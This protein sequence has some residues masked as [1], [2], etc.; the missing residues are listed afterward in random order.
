MEAERDTS[1]ADELLDDLLPD[2]LDWRAMVT[3]YPL[4]AV[5]VSTLGGFFLARRHGSAILEALSSFAATEV[6]RNVSAFLGHDD[7]AGD[8]AD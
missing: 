5:A 4:A 6:D 2:N 8:A 3:S 7:G 1:F